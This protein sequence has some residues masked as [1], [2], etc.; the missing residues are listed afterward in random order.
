MIKK[1]L[2]YLFSITTII[3]G[4][5]NYTP[6]YDP[7]PHVQQ[8][9]LPRGAYVACVDEI[10]AELVQNN[11]T[12]LNDLISTI[13]KHNLNFIAMYGLHRIVDNSPS[14]NPDETELRNILVTLR[15]QF[16]NLKIGATGGGR[17]DQATGTF[18]AQ[19]FETLITDDFYFT[20]TPWLACPTFEEPY[21]SPEELGGLM[22]PGPGASP[23]QKY[24]AEVI[25][26]FARISTFF[27]NSNQQNSS[28]TKQSNS[29]EL[30]GYAIPE[31]SGNLDYFDHFVLED[32]WWQHNP[33]LSAKF[34]YHKQIIQSMQ[35]IRVHNQACDAK[36]I[37]YE[38]IRN[39]FGYPSMIQQAQEIYNLVDRVLVTHY[40]RCVTN[41][42]ERYCEAVEAWGAV[43]NGTTELWPLF[44][45]EKPGPKTHCSW[46]G[47]NW[48]DFWGEWMDQSYTSTNP[49]PGGCAS[50]GA[51]GFGYP[52]EV[53]EAE[54]FY[55]QRL[56]TGAQSNSLPVGSACSNF[57][58]GNFEAD[59]FMWFLTHLMR[60]QGIKQKFQGNIG[61]EYKEKKTLNVYPNPSQ[62]R[63]YV[64][65]GELLE[66]LSL[67]GQRIEVLSNLPYIDV[68]KLERGVY[69]A[70]FKVGNS[71]EIVKII[72][73]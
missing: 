34:G 32:E 68:S 69:I 9:N 54:D 63:V 65:N 7:S 10:T 2:S 67:S 39:H 48:D 72:K 36:I 6:V 19:D 5:Q 13:S 51:P 12:R 71:T 37:V 62:N 61:V 47:G 44:S 30:K 57:Q 28:Q 33:S 1:V 8:H 4:A 23:D 56:A 53:D 38:N 11:S 25:K 42:L 16:P 35:S 41:T 27:G 3:C 21:Y 17:Y 45:V 59:G 55:I 49:P 50:P 31:P 58:P 14:D 40:F 22:N 29:G 52:Y 73:Q 20:P 60:D 18:K 24:M 46:F 66:L 15:T 70:R 64:E 26:F 43:H